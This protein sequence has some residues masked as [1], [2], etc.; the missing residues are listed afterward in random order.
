MKRA[1]AALDR[2]F[3]KALRGDSES[4]LL[5][6]FGEKYPRTLDIRKIVADEAKADKIAGLLAGLVQGPTFVFGLPPQ[7]PPL[8]DPRFVDSKSNNV[9]VTD[10]FRNLRDGLHQCFLR[11]LRELREPLIRRFR[12]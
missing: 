1:V 12:S 5:E 9:W 6:R 3:D 8:L 10:L 2:L 4:L 7:R 11:E